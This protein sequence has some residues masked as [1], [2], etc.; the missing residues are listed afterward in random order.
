MKKTSHFVC[1]NC[2]Y[3]SPKWFGKCPSCGAWNTARQ[4]TNV[5]GE[6]RKNLVEPVSL[7]AL[8]TEPRLKRIRT[9]F[10][11][12]DE[13][14]SGGLLP[15]QVILLGGEP[16]VGKSSLALQISCHL[17][18]TFKVLYVSAEESAEQVGY[19]AA[20]F[21]CRFKDN[22]VVLSEND[23]Q[24]VL[25]VLD[26]SYEFLVLDSLQAMYSEQVGAYPGSIAQVRTAASLIT[27]R[28]KQ[29]SIP[30]LLIAHITK[31]GEIAGPKMVEHLVDTVIYFEG[32]ANTDYRVL[33]VVKN[34]FGPSGEMCIF[35][36]TELGLKQIDESFLIDVEEPPAGNCLS[37]VIEGSKP[38]V[39]QLQALV[40]KTRSVSPRRVSNGYDLTRLLMLIAILERQARLSLES[41]DVYVNVMGGLRITDTAADLAVACAIV[42]S[43][44]EVPLGRTAALGEISLDGRIRPVHRIK[45]RLDALS[46]IELEK[47]LLPA[48]SDL[49]NNCRALKDVRSLL[50]VLGVRKVDRE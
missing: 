47:I 14:L 10:F 16:G 17:A 37:C 40:S 12:L 15:G 9:G 36:M 38:L 21:D 41:R 34:R 11:E 3:E 27:E 18:S 6:R 46:R 31:S 33:R 13:A 7:T 50:D 30:A 44:T 26:S 8:T 1:E 29:L 25:N 2:G 49:A 39:V 42:S 35:E 23:P 48:S 19:R 32:E 5:E 20:R 45:N 4:V 28:C 24:G 43:L 22:V